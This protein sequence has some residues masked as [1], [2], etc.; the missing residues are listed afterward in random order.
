MISE[1]TVVLKTKIINNG[2]QI[3]ETIE[4]NETYFEISKTTIKIIM[5]INAP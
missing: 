1:G 5:Q 2:K 4:L 3:A